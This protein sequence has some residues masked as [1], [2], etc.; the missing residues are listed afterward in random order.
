[1]NYD[2]KFDE[3]AQAL[4]VHDVRPYEMRDKFL[5]LKNLFIILGAF[6]R[7]SDLYLLMNVIQGQKVAG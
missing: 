1:M 3:D 2:T 7:I 5:N 6:W 4:D